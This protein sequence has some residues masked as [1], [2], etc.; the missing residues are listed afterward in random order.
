MRV[1]NAIPLGCPLFVPVHIVNCVQTLKAYPAINGLPGCGDAAF[2][3]GVLRAKWGFDGFVISDAGAVQWMGVPRAVP[4]GGTGKYTT[5]NFT[6][7]DPETA[8]AALLSGTDVELPV[9]VFC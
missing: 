3:N 7:S 6:S 8:A 4:V 5:F 1:T 2:Q 9:V